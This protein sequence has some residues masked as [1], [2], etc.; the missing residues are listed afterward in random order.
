M[1][2]TVAVSAHAH[3][4]AFDLLRLAAASI[5]IFS[6]AY[7]LLGLPDGP[8]VHF[9]EYI[10]AGGLGVGIFFSLSGYLNGLSVRRHAVTEFYIF[11][12]LRIFPALLVNLVITAVLIGAFAT[13]LPPHDY[14]RDHQVWSYMLRGATLSIQENLPGVFADNRY[15]NAVNASL[16]TLPGE[17]A[18]YLLLPLSQLARDRAGHM[19]IAAALFFAVV[20]ALTLG[21]AGLSDYHLGFGPLRWISADAAMFFVGAALA[22]FRLQFGQVRT[23][24]AALALFAVTLNAAYSDLAML[25]TLPLAT[26]AIGSLRTAGL[27]PRQ[28]ISY[29]LYIYAFPIQQLVYDK[30][31]AVVSSF[32]LFGISTV[33]AVAVAFASWRLVEKP[34]IDRRWHISQQLHGW[35][36]LPRAARGHENP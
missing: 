19:N 33:I 9:V 35:M 4:N 23:A 24:V 6:H 22:S 34:I 5:V 15:P 3:R 27:T 26:I 11:R 2:E 13:T 16:W 10:G 7:A 31:H 1:G 29:G 21:P 12:A 30:L 20:H 8:I 25:I 18:L 36:G 32:A 17:F 14:F 28:D